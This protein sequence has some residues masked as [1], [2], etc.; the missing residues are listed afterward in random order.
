MKINTKL[1]IFYFSYNLLR[2]NEYTSPSALTRSVS[3]FRQN[4][5]TCKLLDQKIS[6]S[7]FFLYFFTFYLFLN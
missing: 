6:Q 3:T 4:P 2:D 1:I 7:N 5:P